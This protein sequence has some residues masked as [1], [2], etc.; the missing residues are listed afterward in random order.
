[1]ITISLILLK[2]MIKQWNRVSLPLF[3]I[4]FSLLVFQGYPFE[5]VGICNYFKALISI[6]FILFHFILFMGIGYGDERGRRGSL[7]FSMICYMSWL[8]VSIFICYVYLFIYLFIYYYYYYCKLS[9]I[10]VC[11]FL[12][13]VSVLLK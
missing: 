12:V 3:S 2:V 4:P 11:G 1:M 6:F 9:H 10:R 5:K 8:T 13:F 7:I